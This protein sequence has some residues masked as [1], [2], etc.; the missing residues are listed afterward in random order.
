MNPT[1]IITRHAIE[2]YQQRVDRTAN[3]RDAAIAISQILDHATARPRPRRW[4]RVVAQVA[5]TRYLYS[6]RRPGVCLVVAD[7]AVVTVHSRAVCASWRH[8]D[9]QRQEG[10]EMRVLRARR[11][12]DD[13]WA[14]AA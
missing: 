11:T 6:A 14:D 8:S 5:G 3:V 13:W 7:G 12:G 10:R 1:P 4:S 9:V 2:R